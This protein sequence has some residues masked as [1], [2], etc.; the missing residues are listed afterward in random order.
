MV[1]HN[2]TLPSC[3]VYV[4]TREED[5]ATVFSVFINKKLMAFATYNEKED[6]DGYLLF[7]SSCSLVLLIG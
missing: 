1:L 3:V 2:T 4:Y 6:G 5:D 7:S